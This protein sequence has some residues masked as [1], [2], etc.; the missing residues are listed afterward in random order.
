MDAMKGA[1]AV[2]GKAKIDESFKVSQTAD[3]L[4]QQLK[5]LLKVLPSPYQEA[6]PFMGAI[7]T[8][9]GTG[10]EGGKSAVIIDPSGNKFIFGH[11]IF[12]PRIG[13]FPT[14]PFPYPLNSLLQLEWMLYF[15]SSKLTLSLKRM[16]S[17]MGS[18]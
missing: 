15:I 2:V 14:L 17:L 1:M 16:A 13:L 10:S 18:I 3:F 12:F 11:P 8:T 4:V 6:I 7:P 9:A 5:P